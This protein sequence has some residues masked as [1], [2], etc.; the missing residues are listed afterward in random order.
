MWNLPATSERVPR[1]TPGEINQRLRERTLGELERLEHAT[2][3]AITARIESL[4]REWDIERTLEA[5]AASLSLVGLALAAFVD[6]RFVVL[7]A[8]IAGFLL[9]HAL[10]GWCPPLTFFRRR[11]VR[12]SAEIH[13]EITALRILRG[14][15]ADVSD[16]RAALRKARLSSPVRG[17]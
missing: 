17:R 7:P 5:N 9:Q 13:E 15:F 8:A 4:R 10:Q 11:G 6:R 2:P 14:D 1:H 12:T 3:A 16:A